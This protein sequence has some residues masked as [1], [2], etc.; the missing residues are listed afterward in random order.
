[1]I[2]QLMI[3]AGPDRGRAVPM[4]F[5]PI[6]IGRGRESDTALS[7][8]YVSRAHCRIELRGTDLTLVD[9]G[10]ISGTFVNDARVREHVLHMGDVIRVG[11]TQFRLE[12]DMADQATLVPPDAVTRRPDRDEPLPIAAAP[13]ARKM[14]PP[15]AAPERPTAL[16]KPPLPKTPPPAAAEL[17]VLPGNRL[18]E[19]VGTVLAHFRIGPALAKGTSGIVFQAQDQRNDRQV[20]LKVLR[21]EFARDPVAV[22][23]FIRSMKTVLPLRHPNLVTLY[24]A[25]KKGPYCW[26]AM[27]YVDG[28]SLT[29]II[30]RIGVVGM[31][32][33]KKAYWV[34]VHVGRALAFAHSQHIIH[35]NLTPQNVM[36]QEKDKV[37]RLGDLM[38]AKAFEGCN[39]ED[40]TQP[41]EILGD[42]RYMPPERTGG[43]A[44]LDGRSDIYS[45]GALVY[46]L[47]TGKPPFEGSSLVQT[48]LLIREGKL[49]PP[50]QYQLS[51]PDPFQMVV[52]RMLA[53]DPEDRFQTAEQLLKELE[54]V[55]KFQGLLG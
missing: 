2:V 33:W 29:A 10:S 22:Q 34:A 43:T 20:A 46:A 48:L 9:L 42:V 37:A 53:R 3:I 14:S 26:V 52:L 1:M 24:G 40:I 30:R 4:K 18:G 32:D 25:G 41:G 51:I 15:A 35:R 12:D 27:E 49:V 6:N 31:L 47:L 8:P 16:K 17:P 5:Y 28:E 55:G 7:D 50:R 39:E 13:P 45:L 19:L 36:V 44:D 38:L 11:D 21:A 23:R 54:R